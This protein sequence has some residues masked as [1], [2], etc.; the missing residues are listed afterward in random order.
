MNTKNIVV[1][2]IL[3]GIAGYLFL[4]T[5]RESLVFE[6]NVECAQFSRKADQKIDELK[7]EWGFMHTYEKMEIFYSPAFDSCV[8]LYR[9][10]NITKQNLD[11]SNDIPSISWRMYD[12][13]KDK[14][15]FDSFAS[16]N[17]FEDIPQP[18]T[19]AIIVFKGSNTAKA[20]HLSESSPLIIVE[21]QVFEDH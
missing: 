15:I 16:Q 6:R 3:L 13:L 5:N 7:R 2:V 4:N 20:K 14:E 1:V 10:Y 9:R 8:L 19:D 11:G 21:G 17:Y 12:L 18:I